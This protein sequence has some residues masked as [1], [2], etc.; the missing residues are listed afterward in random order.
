MKP[1]V[2]LTR[3]VP[4][5]AMDY[6]A[7]RVDLKV[8]PGDLPVPRPLLLRE[9]RKAQGLIS[10]LTERVDGELLDHAP[11]LKVVAN[12]AVGFDNVD[13]GAAT[14]RGVPVTNTP[15]VL[16]ETTADMAW[17]LMMAVARR[18]VEGD[19]FVRSGRWETWKPTFMLGRDVHGKTLGI[20]GMGRI[21]RAMARRAQGFGM[22][23]LY[24][25]IVALPAAEERRLGAK[26]VSLPQLLRQSDFVTLHTV[27]TPE[28][29]HL[30]GAREFS[31]MKPTAILIN[32]SR[33]PVVDERALVRALRSGQIAGAGLDVFEREPRTAPGLASLKNV[34][35]QPHAA[36]GTL[37]TRT[38][39]G[40]VAVRNCL[41][42][43]AG[44]R[45]PNLV[46]PE[47]WPKRRR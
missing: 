24:T 47:V 42:A 31:L 46:N 25:D 39:M 5:A 13:L 41:A 4:Q 11:G 8:Y 37:E 35:L 12:Y 18:M 14:E 15:E 29:R 27:L 10:L 45:P 22:K 34:V 16:T 44:R 26:R 2:F 30:I 36:S 9:A 43:L 6:L 20:V 28:T 33:G 3:K 38:A 32:A 40:M 1:R 17:T 19:A 7:A 21:G 23:V